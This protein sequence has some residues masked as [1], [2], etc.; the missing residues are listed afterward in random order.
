[1]SSLIKI[2]HGHLVHLQK[3]A[4]LLCH[5]LGFKGFYP[6]REKSLEGIT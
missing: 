5:G 3:L 1:L 6:E 4:V 2:A